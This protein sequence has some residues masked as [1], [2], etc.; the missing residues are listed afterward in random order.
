[1]AQKYSGLGIEGRITAVVAERM[2]VVW[3]NDGERTGE[4]V[5]RTD[6]LTPALMI[7]A[8]IKSRAV[9]LDNLTP[10]WRFHHDRQG[11]FGLSVE[12][13]E[14]HRPRTT[15]DDVF[16]AL[17]AAEGIQQMSDA[18]HSL[19]QGDESYRG[20][21]RKRNGQTQIELDAVRAVLVRA[22]G[23]DLGVSP[24]NGVRPSSPEPTMDDDR[25][26]AG[27]SRSPELGL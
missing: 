6:G 25:P 13:V 5:Y 2:N 12:F 22:Y 16:T 20:A 17:L 18:V 27:P 26:A 3:L 14:S 24:A 7:P 19:Q 8:A 23:T 10:P 4:D 9:M 15:V 1:M 11:L 21:I